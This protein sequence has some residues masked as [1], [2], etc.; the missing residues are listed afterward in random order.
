MTSGPAVCIVD[1]DESVRESL[2]GLLRS[3]GFDARP[4]RSAE[5]F[6]AEGDRS[7]MRC[8]ILDVTMP[9][10]SGAD[11][12]ERLLEE[13]L[14]FPIVFITARTEPTLHTRLLQ[15]GAVA[16]F[17]KPFHED[18]LLDTVRAATRRP[19]T[20]EGGRA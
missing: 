2:T 13:G 5:H 14:T 1:D 16:C 7:A 6:L 8:A 10:L 17:V 9:G 19:R 20:A 4:F 18:E 15:R 3:A 11:L 12:Q